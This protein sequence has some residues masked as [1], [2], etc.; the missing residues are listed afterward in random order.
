[1]TPS[2]DPVEPA[3]TIGVDE[4]TMPLGMYEFLTGAPISDPLPPGFTLEEVEGVPFVRWQGSFHAPE[5]AP[6]T[7]EDR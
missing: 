1:M 2:T 3:A 5:T 7:E 4:F 6:E